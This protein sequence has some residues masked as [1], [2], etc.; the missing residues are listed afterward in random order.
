MLWTYSAAEV[1]CILLQTSGAAV[2]AD[3]ANALY[4]RMLLLAG[5]GLQ[6]YFLSALLALVAAMQWVPYFGFRGDKAF[7]PVFACLYA[8]SGL[9]NLRTIFRMA[10]FAQGYGRDISRHEAYLYA[11][12]FVPMFL[13]FLLFGALHYGGWLGPDAPAQLYRQAQG[14]KHLELA[15]AFVNKQQHQQ[16]SQPQPQQG[17]DDVLHIHCS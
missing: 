14:T 2:Y 5:L 16:H 3:R 4:G 11:L 7:R 9:I 10:E 15:A 13:C 6:L 17:G 12:D 1:V 8:T